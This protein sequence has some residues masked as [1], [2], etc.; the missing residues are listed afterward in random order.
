MPRM[1][2]GPLPAHTYFSQQFRGKVTI[3]PTFLRRQR[4][5]MEE[6]SLSGAGARVRILALPLTT[7]TTWGKLISAF[8]SLKWK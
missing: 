7:L 5:L 4:P 1:L 8:L 3:I 6:H 2:E